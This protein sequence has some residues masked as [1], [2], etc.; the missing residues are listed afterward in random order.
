MRRRIRVILFQGPA[1]SPGKSRL[2]D[3]REIAVNPRKLSIALAS[4]VVLCAAASAHAAAPASAPMATSV[5]MAAA[6]KPAA[7]KKSTAPAKPASGAASASSTSA[8]QVDINSASAKELKTLP[9]IGDAEAAK[10]IAGRP[11]GSKAHLVTRN[12]IDDGQY[13]SIKGRIIAKQPYKDGAKNAAL[14]APKK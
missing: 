6:S 9:G 14:Y 1:A 13:Q 10:I 7:A 12:I 3:S 2:S 11:Y 8:K 4:A 5:P